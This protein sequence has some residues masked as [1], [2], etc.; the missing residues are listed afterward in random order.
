NGNGNNVRFFSSRMFEQLTDEDRQ[1]V[2][3]SVSADLRTTTEDVR[4]RRALQV[5]STEEWKDLEELARLR[6]ENIVLTWLK[7]A[8]SVNGKLNT[9]AS[10][11]TWSFDHLPLF[12]EHSRTLFSF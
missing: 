1:A 7:N 11:M 5:V 9:Q 8:N 3:K 4:I 2:L 12:S 6:A 10:L